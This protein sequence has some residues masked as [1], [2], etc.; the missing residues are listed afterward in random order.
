M[1]RTQHI[2]ARFDIAEY[3]LCR[4]INRGAGLRS[5]RVAMQVASRLGDGLVW[6]ALIGLL[7]L[8]YCRI[9]VRPAM[10]MAVTG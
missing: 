8:L 1:T 10:V 3:R 4:G 6:Y 9:A 7:P 2:V 5:L